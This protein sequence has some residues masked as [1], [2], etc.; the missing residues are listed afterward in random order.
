MGMAERYLKVGREEEPS[1]IGLAG[2]SQAEPQHGQM[3]QSSFCPHAHAD[4]TRYPAGS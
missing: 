3:P 2:V 4:P 1:E